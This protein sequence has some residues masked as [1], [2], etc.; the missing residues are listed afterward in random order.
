MNFRT[1]SAK[2]AYLPLTASIIGF[3]GL[4][5]VAFDA[6]CASDGCIG[7]VV[8]LAGGAFSAIVQVTVC[9]PIYYKQSTQNKDYKNRTFVGWFTISMAIFCLTY[10]L[11]R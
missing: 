4:W 1:D 9:L 3:F 5:A 7:V 6:S 8:P 2:Y 10:I 11:V